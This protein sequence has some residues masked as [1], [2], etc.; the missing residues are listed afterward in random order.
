MNPSN[1]ER[2]SLWDYLVRFGFRL[3]YQEMAWSYDAVAWLVSF[4]QWKK[5]A[6][7]ALPYLKGKK[8]LELGPGPGHLMLTLQEQ[9][10][11]P[12]GIDLSAQMTRLAQNRLRR[13]GRASHLVR[14]R[15]P[16]FPFSDSVFDTVVATFPTTYIFKHAT[17]REVKRILQSNG[18][19]IVVTGAQVHSR[20]PLA[21]FIEWLY[22]ITGQRETT[23]SDW[24]S[25]FQAADLTVRQIHVTLERST[26]FLLL[27]RPTPPYDTD[28][29]TI[30]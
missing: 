4:G 12:I 26:V 24:K 17:L 1:N 11:H 25:V 27:A 5:W 19:L 10:F 23:A 13:A 3:L 14:G 21:R 29:Q 28:L 20:N 2:F 7:T 9:G 15:A 8:V 6:Q 18:R 30:G 22:T 16:L